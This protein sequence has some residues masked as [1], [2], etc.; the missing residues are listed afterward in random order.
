MAREEKSKKN[1]GKKPARP[2]LDLHPE[3]KKTV[4]GII[5]FAVSA[6]LVFSYF[7][8]AGRAGVYIYQVFYAFLGVGLFPGPLMRFLIALGVF[9]SITTQLYFTSV[10]GGVL[11]LVRFLG[12]L[13]VI[14]G[15][16]GGQVQDASV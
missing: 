3:T 15:Q 9:P 8:S 13:T 10:F 5:F 11:F 14:Y 4:L 7:G 6:I 12:L 2:R 16:W 1:N